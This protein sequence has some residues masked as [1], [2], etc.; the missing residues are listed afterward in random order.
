VRRP[1]DV[2]TNAVLRLQ[3]VGLMETVSTGCRDAEYALGLFEA[4]DPSDELHPAGL[5][6]MHAIGFLI[7]LNTEWQAATGIAELT[8]GLPAGRTV[9]EALAAA[10]AAAPAVDV[11]TDCVHQELGCSTWPDCGGLTTDESRL[12]CPIFGDVGSLPVTRET[13]ALFSQ[14]RGSIGAALS[15]GKAG[16][17]VDGK[18]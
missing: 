15:P 2:R 5:R 1:S 11:L 16:A 6:R 17:S 3:L 7:G 9:A 4:I 18:D 10:R 14:L 13:L 12:S 8:K